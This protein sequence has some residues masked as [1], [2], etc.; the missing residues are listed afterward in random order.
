MKLF[1][2]QLSTLYA[3]LIAHSKPKILLIY[4]SIVIFP[5]YAT[6]YVIVSVI[7]VVNGLSVILHH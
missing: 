2:H 4:S 5:C 1:A 6:T 3:V 7:T